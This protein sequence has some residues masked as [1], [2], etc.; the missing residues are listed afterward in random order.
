MKKLAL[1]L[2]LLLLAGGAVAIYQVEKRSPKPA[3]PTVLSSYVAAEGK[4]EAMPGYDIN[5]GTGEL[6]AKVARILVREGDTVTA[7][8]LVA[9][10]D[11]AD[12]R[13]QAQA[14]E[15][16][17]A[18]AQSRLN[19]VLAGSRRGSG[20]GERRRTGSRAPVSAL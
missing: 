18:V 1:P 20:G 15:R 16:Q 19:E 4:V 12:L 9:V 3:T 2:L 14:A 17:L 10:L 8:Q 11:N 7:G 5:L 6:N 13:A